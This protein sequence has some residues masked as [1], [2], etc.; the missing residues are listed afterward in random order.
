MGE[1]GTFIDFVSSTLMIEVC[2]VIVLLSGLNCMQN[3][4]PPTFKPAAVAPS[5]DSSSICR[6]PIRQA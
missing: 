5:R 2:I 4:I 1:S 6:L 3:V